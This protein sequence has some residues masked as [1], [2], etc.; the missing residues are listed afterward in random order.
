MDARARI[1]GYFVSAAEQEIRDEDDIFELGIVDSLFAIR[2]IQFVEKEF[3]ITVEREDLDI[4]NFCS[5]AALT[6]F[7]LQKM[8]TATPLEQQ[9][10]PSPK[11]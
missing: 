10:H 5:I 7:A 8:S 4:R 6:K 2:L 3:A 9:R 11:D 1:R